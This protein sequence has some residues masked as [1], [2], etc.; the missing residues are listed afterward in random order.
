MA[1]HGAIIP[2]MTIFGSDG[3]PVGRVHRVSG[4]RIVVDR[5]GVTD[6]DLFYIPLSWV[7]DVTDRV[8]LDRPA[9]DAQP[10]REQA[11]ERKLRRSLIITASV[12][13]ALIGIGLVFGVR[14]AILRT[15][16]TAASAPATVAVSAAPPVAPMVRPVAPKPA[17]PAVLAKVSGPVMAGS[18][19]MIGYLES[20]APVPRGFPIDGAAFAKGAAV[21][22]PGVQPIARMMATHLNTRIK[23]AVLPGAGGVGRGRAEAMRSALIASGIAPYRIATGPARITRL[24]SKSGVALVVL[25]K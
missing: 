7:A 12:I 5:I 18:A 19:P 16:S 3:A 10:E 6:T 11:D 2:D 9:A 15:Q 25:A 1:V 23:L 17:A 20:D 24:A 22:A 13:I 8:T 4:V 14:S 21:S